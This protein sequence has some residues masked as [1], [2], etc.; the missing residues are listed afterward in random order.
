MVENFIEEFPLSSSAGLAMG[1]R[2]RFGSG[3]THLIFQLMR[4]LAEAKGGQCKPIYAKTDKVDFLD[5]YINYFARKFEAADLKKVVSLH[6]A[7]LLRVK[8]RPSTDQGS[9]ETVSISDGTE[10]TAT[11]S[12]AQIAQEEVDQL[13]RTDPQ[14][15][16][17]LVEG[18]LLPVSGLS[19]DFDQE[20]ESTERKQALSPDGTNAEVVIG[21]ASDVSLDFFRAYSKLTDPNLGPL[22]VRW[23][24][25]SQLSNSERVDLGLESAGINQPSLAK[26]AM[27]FLLAAFKKADFAVV[28]CLDEFERFSSRGTEADVNACA[29]LL[30]D[31]AEIFQKTGH[32]LIVS[33]V[34]D[35]WR[36]MPP[37]VFA[38]IKPADIVQMNLSESEAR[39]LVDVYCKASG[40]SVESLF[41]KDDEQDAFHLAY[42]ASNHNTRRILDLCHKSYEIAAET[43]TSNGES[44]GTVRIEEGHIE[45]AANQVLSTAKRQEAVGVIIRAA[46]S[47]AGL[48]VQTEFS[49]D[50]LRCDYVL[51]DA[52]NPRIAVEVTQSI[53]KLGEVSA[54]RKIADL[55]QQIRTKFPRMEF[56]VV[57]VGYSTKEVRDDL[58]RVVD[59]VFS[60]DEDRFTTEFRE[61]LKSVQLKP[62]E[63]ENRLK[64][65]EYAYQQLLEKFDELE[66][67]RRGEIAQLKEA[68]ETLQAESLRTRETARDRRVT[69]KMGETLDELDQLLDQEEELA[70]ST[71]SK[72][73]EEF[74]DTEDKLTFVR[75]LIDEQF[76]HFSRAKILNERLPRAD[77]FQD[78]LKTLEHLTERTLAKWYDTFRSLE[79]NSELFLDRHERDLFH[80]RRALLSEL[81]SI[82]FTRKPSEGFDAIIEGLRQN[83]V[84]VTLSLLSTLS[85]VLVLYLLSSAWNNEKQAI[86]YYSFQ[87]ST[88]RGKIRSAHVDLDTRSSAAS[89]YSLL[90]DITSLEGNP[91]QQTYVV[92]SITSARLPE[93]RDEMNT[94]TEALSAAPRDVD[95]SYTT[96]EVLPKLRRIEVL[97]AKLQSEITTISFG[98]FVGKFFRFH[99]IF[100]SICALPLI[101][102]VELLLLKRMRLL[103]QRRLATG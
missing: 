87:L 49:M 55:S 62:K 41:K 27:R 40:A 11:K 96:S 86:G 57:I 83:K 36:V 59:R 61:F 7:R 13:L 79:P 51:G 32:L 95:R 81:E 14:G 78:R 26:E 37:D 53:F 67:A 56:G 100:T 64:N 52:Q 82:H 90:T 18:D 8:S 6:L 54:A 66:S 93:I 4:E 45:R 15:V 92:A 74:V 58:A 28:F 25:G 1:I 2:G 16:L 73:K 65:Q 21:A 84:S 101:L 46:A 3:K 91:Y 68:L 22:A 63:V 85:V 43:N 9:N 71:R 33:G 102:L 88:I 98:T 89:T 75:R 30:K 20:I 47:D 76:A 50:G 17:A 24:Q 97:C 48:P 77:E 39:G 12:L 70:F 69:D 103:R 80:H 29:G 31:L 42:E 38:R 60:F 34:E 99:W 5:V 23:I 10:G 44:A 94:L 19:R 35:A 72:G